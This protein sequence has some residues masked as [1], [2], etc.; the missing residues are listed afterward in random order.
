VK[1]CEVGIINKMRIIFGF[2]KNPISSVNTASCFKAYFTPTIQYNPINAIFIARMH[3]VS[4]QHL[5]KHL[6]QEMYKIKKTIDNSQEWDYPT[7]AGEKERIIKR[8]T[9]P[10][11]YCVYY[12]E[13]YISFY[14]TEAQKTNSFIRGNKNIPFSIALSEIL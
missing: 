14:N 5:E 7:W 10:S 8:T 9:T 6:Q 11:F 2:K 1:Y 13:S 4:T 3:N 12:T